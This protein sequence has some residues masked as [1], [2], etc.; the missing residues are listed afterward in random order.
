MIEAVQP[1]RCPDMSSL[2]VSR[3]LS[4]PRSVNQM[5]GFIYLQ[6]VAKGKL[7]IKVNSKE[8]QYK[9]VISGNPAD[10]I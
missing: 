9:L 4:F 10:S 7:F 5:R 3:V 6:N 8:S 1:C 2:A